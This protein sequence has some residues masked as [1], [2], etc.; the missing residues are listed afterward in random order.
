ML[1][2]DVHHLNLDRLGHPWLDD[3]EYAAL[4]RDYVPADSRSNRLIT[5]LVHELTGTRRR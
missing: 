1:D 5:L 2:E 4:R 3:P